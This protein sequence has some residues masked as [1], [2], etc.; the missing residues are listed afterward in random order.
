MCKEVTPRLHDNENQNLHCKSQTRFVFSTQSLQDNGQ[1]QH[2]KQERAPPPPKH[3]QS[4]QQPLACLPLPR[5]LLSS[6]HTCRLGRADLVY[7]NASNRAGRKSPALK[8]IPSRSWK[9]LGIDFPKLL[10]WNTFTFGLRILTRVR[11]AEFSVC[12]KGLGALSATLSTSPVSGQRASEVCPSSCNDRDAHH[13]PHSASTPTSRLHI[14]TA[15][16]TECQL[17]RPLPHGALSLSP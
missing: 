12:G 17:Q 8:E 11:W 4:L 5:T 13:V 1:S 14:L 10:V 16:V 9:D 15:A 2:H 3:L 6:A 7:T